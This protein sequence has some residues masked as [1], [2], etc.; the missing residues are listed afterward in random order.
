MST[1]AL[2][3]DTRSAQRRL[4][5]L[6][7]QAMLRLRMQ[8]AIKATVLSGTIVAWLLVPLVIADK[9]F[10][11]SA[12]GFSIWIVW[13]G[14]AALCIPYI[15]MRAFSNRIH[16]QFAAIVA[17][18]RL[19]LHSRLAT[20]LSLDPED[21][22]GFSE[23]FYHEAADRLAKLDPAKA[24]PIQL[25]K[26]AYF[27][28]PAAAI[29]A[30][31]YYF[32][33]QRDLAGFIAKAQQKRHAEDLK[34]NTAK[35]LEA[36]LEDLKKDQETT[37]PED[38]AQFK[39]NQLVKKA[40]AIAKELKEG[41]RDPNEAVI[42]LAEL[43]REIG[44]Q[45]DKIDSDGK[46]LSER[47]KG[48]SEKDLNLEEND[49]T[50]Q[51]SEALKEG[52]ADLAAKEMRKLARKIKNEI[53]NDSSKTDEQKAEA[54]QKLEKEIEKL[55]GALEDE[56]NVGKD[57]MEAAKKAMDSSEYQ[58]LQ[59]DIKKQL[60][61][62]DGKNN[63][64][65]GE[66]LEKELNE[67]AEDLENKN[68]DGE[69]EVSE[70]EEKADEQLNELEEG[71]DSAMEGLTEQGGECKG[72]KPGENGKPGTQADGKKAGGQDGKSGKSGKRVAGSKKSGV[73]Q[74]Q[75]AANGNQ[76]KQGQQQNGGDNK[77]EKND[78]GKPNPAFSGPNQGGPGMGKR[79]YRDGDALFKSEMVRGKMQSGAI[80][81]LS[82]FRG[83]GAKGD[84]PTQYVQALT[85]A[86]QDATSSLEL[87]RIPADSRELVKDYFSKLKQDTGGSIKPAVAPT[88]GGAPEQA[89]APA[90]APKPQG[91]ALKE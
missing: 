50:K 32:V 15:L 6:V 13:G 18:E 84:A 83:Q 79:A 12:L 57:L 10:S 14:L 17:D 54:M 43:K 69:K 40:D 46:D 59:E 7:A 39:V 75:Q 45:K 42:A 36:K 22:S 1:V 23:A 34:Q 61:Q 25:P 73:K 35:Q 55:A 64:S 60:D 27:I 62:Q 86:E 77:G 51:I 80:T 8:E 82:H 88:P 70:E 58:K 90:P 76:G 71:V 53:L 56:G 48:L 29:S 68:D 5:G 24:F 20:A 74:G 65:M 67:A 21:D 9:C 63:E 33:P 66:Q 3:L 41:K 30:A 19:G 37:P 47:L 49:Y 4:H 44:E 87:D 89:P 38:S 91:E 2:S 85:A 11:L 16:Q 28:L 81:G 78:G 26:M 52:D 72:C 31:L